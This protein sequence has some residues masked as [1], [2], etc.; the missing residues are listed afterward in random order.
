MGD[1][2]WAELYSSAPL[3]AVLGVIAWKLWQRD[4]TRE[5]REYEERKEERRKNDAHAAAVLALLQQTAEGI[6]RVNSR[7][8]RSDSDA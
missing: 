3:A 4:E 7:F 6:A 2:I 8:D 5:A 1:T